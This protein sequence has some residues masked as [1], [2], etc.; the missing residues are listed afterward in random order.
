[1]DAS[2][3][4]TS[5]Y[6]LGIPDLFR[7][8]SYLWIGLREDHPRPVRIDRK[9]HEALTSGSLD[10]IPCS[11]I[12]LLLEHKIIVYKNE[13]EFAAI[14]DENKRRKDVNRTLKRV[15]MPSANCSLGCN[16][17]KYGGY[18]G[19]I[20]HDVAISRP[21]IDRLVDE[22]SQELETGKY[23]NLELGF[24]GAE[25]LIEPDQII[26]CMNRV[27]AICS[28]HKV[29]ISQASIVT[30]GL[31]LNISL[32]M[33][34]YGCGITD[35]EVTLDGPR[36]YHDRRRC[37]KGGKPTFDRIYSNLKELAA[38]QDI[39]GLG[40]SIRMN[41]D[42]RNIN[43]VMDLFNQIESDGLLDRCTFYISPIRNWGINTAADNHGCGDIFPKVEMSVLHKLEMA[44][45]RTGLIPPRKYITCAAVDPNSKV[46]D[47]YG[48][49][50]ACT[51]TPLTP[52]SHSLLQIH[53]SWDKEWEQHI[54]SGQVPCASCKI[55]P[56]CGGRC[57]KDWF[58]GDIPCPA[59][60]VNLADRI[61]LSSL[62]E[63]VVE[64]S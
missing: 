21:H 38:C 61:T 23:S 44:G 52:T 15:I 60:K 1:M 16:L 43:S 48:Q 17:E 25:P 54:L 32:A 46:M 29:T 45:I 8:D 3:Y 35:V 49:M 42:S 64:A 7:L 58:N 4:K 24:F 2:L 34:L 13:E 19:Q 12:G 28:E 53:K 33:R 47:P 9:C 57:P 10:A 50:H 39:I 27:H 20:H 56:I 55:F 6:A 62:V 14:L 37:T 22:L 41:V 59:Y 11:V 31:L 51:E 30:S 5:Y 63:Q 36:E 26:Y 40:I 18:C